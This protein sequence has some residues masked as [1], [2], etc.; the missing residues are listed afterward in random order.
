MPTARGRSL[1]LS[2]AVALSA[3]ACVSSAGDPLDEPAADVSPEAPADATGAPSG[4]ENPS[5]VCGDGDASCGPL[6]VRLAFRAVTTGTKVTV[7]R[8]RESWGALWA[9]HDGDGDPDL[10]VGRHGWQPD[11]LVNDGGTYS[12]A[13]VDFVHPPGYD[14]IDNDSGVDRHSCAWGEANGDGLPDL[15]CAVGADRGTG[16]GPNQLFLGGDERFRDSAGELGVTNA[17]GRSKSVGWLDYEGDGDL[18]LLVGNALRLDRRAPNMLFERNEDHFTRAKAGLDDELV[19]MSMSWADWDV[20]GDPD[21]LALQYP[22]SRQPTVAYENG[23]GCST[24]S[25]CRT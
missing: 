16:V 18:D 15:Y 19:T 25:R 24:R 4:V 3:P 1:V 22:S 8:P 11:L 23:A 7:V 12:R 2:L 13:N 5:S 20:D 10:F 21:V 6:H 14:P 9:D 17:F